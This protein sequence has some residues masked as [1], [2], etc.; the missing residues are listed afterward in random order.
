M[1]KKHE[2]P[3]PKSSKSKTSNTANPSLAARQSTGTQNNGSTRPRAE[4]EGG[5]T[6]ALRATTRSNQTSSGR[7]R[8][9]EGLRSRADADSAIGRNRTS[10]EPPSYIDNYL[11]YRKKAFIKVFMAKICEWLDEHVCPGEEAFDN[12]GERS[13]SSAPAKSR[14]V[15]RA[16]SSGKLNPG[17]KRQNRGDDQEEEQ[18]E[19]DDKRDQDRNKKRSKTDGDDNR[20]R[21]ACPYYKRDPIKYKHHRSCFGPGWPEIHRLKEHLYRRHRLFACKRCFDTFGSEKALDDHSRAAVACP[22]RD[23]KSHK[24]DPSAGMDQETEK[25]LRGRKQSNKQ[26]DMAKWYDIYSTLFPGELDVNKLPSPWYDD[27]ASINRKS[28]ATE[29]EELKRNYEAFLRREMPNL[30][31]RELEKDIE[32]CFED[33]GAGLMGRLAVWIQNSSARCAK[34]FENIPSPSQAAALEDPETARR[35]TSRAA[36]PAHVAENGS[37]GGGVGEPWYFGFPEFDVSNAA[38]LNFD[39][40]A[41]PTEFFPSYDQCHVEYDSAYDTGSH[42]GSSGAPRGYM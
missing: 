2:D 30:I 26:D 23:K 27:P 12:D 22:L 40:L 32:R 11:A 37:T 14:G 17:Q 15:K 33:L 28:G 24:M 21:F 36:S 41:V 5:G 1:P 39:Q 4:R 25:R 18:S 9:T 35:S 8:V 10:P 3:S 42:G 38:Y 6:E 29:S 20:P 19:N 16:A 13:G 34:I 7:S 31:Q